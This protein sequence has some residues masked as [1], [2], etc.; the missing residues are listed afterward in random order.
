MGLGRYLSIPVLFIAIILQTTVIPEIR[1]ARGGPDLILMMVVS[2]GLLT[3]LDEGFWWAIVGGIYQD[4]SSGLPTGVSALALVI[5]V[6]LNKLALGTIE[7]T[8]IFVPPLVIAVTT[9]LYHL[10]LIAALAALNRPVPILPSLAEVTLPTVI[11]NFVL[12]VPMFR[13]MGA[14]FEASRPR[15]VSL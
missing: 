11:F 10:L 15:S 9:V 12:M 1:V 13:L 14:I 4:L 5:I 3:D 6:F 7:R 8:N 2:W